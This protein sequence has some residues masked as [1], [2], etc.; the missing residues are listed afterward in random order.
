MVARWTGATERTVKNWFSGHNAP[1]GDYFLEL[2]RN[3]PD[4]L[5]EFLAAA[6][7][8]ERLSYQRP[9]GMTRVGIPKGAKF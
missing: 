8:T 1:S 5:D 3:C 2:V 9:E 7:Q 4:M 6:G